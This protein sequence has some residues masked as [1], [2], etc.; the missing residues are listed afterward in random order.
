MLT[1]EKIADAAVLG[2]PDVEA[3]ELP[4]AFIVAKT[5]ISEKEVMDYVKTRV[6]PHKCLRGGVIFVDSIPKS[7]SGK[8][9]RRELRVQLKKLM[10]LQSKL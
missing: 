7:A 3:G 6:S 5:K 1:N 8:I 2:R 10:Q 4:M 9:L